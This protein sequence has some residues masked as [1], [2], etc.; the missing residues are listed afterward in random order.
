VTPLAEI[1]FIAA[2][3]LFGV[4]FEAWLNLRIRRNHPKPPYASHAW[5][6]GVG[7]CAGGIEI[8]H[9]HREPSASERLWIVGHY[10]P[11]GGCP[12]ILHRKLHP[13]HEEAWREC[14][15]LN[16][17]LSPEPGAWIVYAVYLQLLPAEKQG[18]PTA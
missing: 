4:S 5:P 13:T 11:E 12:F 16:A 14:A 10:R 8:K 9:C 15:E 18:E 3:F 6:L 7:R 17:K 2:A 1:S